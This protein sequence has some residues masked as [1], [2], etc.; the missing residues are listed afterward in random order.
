MEHNSERYRRKSIR[1][2][3]YDY[4]QA[5]AYFI[6]IC[7]QNKECLFGDV[8]DGE[9]RLNALGE[10]VKTC[11]N[12]LPHRY[13]EVELDYF[14]V[15]PNHVHAII[16]ITNVGAIHEL[17]LPRNNPTD[18]RRILIP[19]IIG[20]AKMTTAKRINQLRNTPRNPL[21]QRNY[22]EHVIRNDDD[23]NRIREYITQN[24]LKWELDEENP[25]NT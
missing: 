9:M 17:P 25:I 10:I 23:L 3:D 16:I 19:K 2:K 24:P 7:T 13:P 4:S 12:D 14:T 21:W 1:I 15:M 20:Y 5:G 6:T 11:W 18:R 8:A 22:Y